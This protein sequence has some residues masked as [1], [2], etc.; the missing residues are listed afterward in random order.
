MSIDNT[1][2]GG[3]ESLTG[4]IAVTAYRTGSSTT[5]SATAYIVSQRGSRQFKIHLEDS[6]EIVATLTAVAA[7][8]L[9]GTHNSFCVQIILNDSTVAYVSKFYNNTVHFVDASGNTGHAF[10][11]LGVEGTDE[12]GGAGA[13]SG[14]S[15]GSIDVR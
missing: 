3:N 4:K 2:A 10:Y 1:L 13:A 6:T 12:E 5:S 14:I 15:S 11:S 9:S 8:S 7:G